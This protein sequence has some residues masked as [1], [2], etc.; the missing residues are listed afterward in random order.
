MK[1]LHLIALLVLA[2]AFS[3]S[4]QHSKVKIPSVQK[5]LN[6]LLITADDLD[7]N[8]LGCFGSTV[9]DISPNIDRFASQ[10]IRFEKAFVNAAICV[11]TRAI[12][13]TGLYGNN[14][15]VNGFNKM[16][17]GST[18]PL[19]MEI[20]RSHNYAVGILGKL[21]HSTPKAD[22]KWDYQFDQ[23]DL[24]FGRSPS[25]YYKRTKAF[26][27]DCRKNDKPFYFMINSQDPHRPFFNPNESA[28]SI[29]RRMNQPKARVEE[30][31]KDQEPPSRI[32]S[33]D[34]ITVPGFLP[35]LPK[36]REELSYYFNS[37]KRLDDAFGKVMQALEESGYADNTLVI[38]ISDNGIALP[39][40]KANVYNVSNRS[41]FIMRWPGTIK[42]G[43]VNNTDIVSIIDFMP[44]VLEALNIPAPKKIDGRSFLPLLKSGTQSGRD[45]AFME[46]DYKNSGG[47][48]PMRSVI[49]TQYN[50]IYN[51]WADGERVYGNN[52][53]GATMRAMEEA[54]KNDSAIAERI[55]VYYMRMPEEL[56]DIKKDP[57]C[58]HNLINEPGLKKQLASLR[59]DL[60]R[61]MIKTNDPLLKVYQVRHQPGKAL[62]EFYRIYPEA[63]EFDKNKENYSKA[64]RSND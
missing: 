9:P 37:V 44:T 43:S 27:D 53:E 28:D 14:S 38:F 8:S 32:Y 17:E 55:K 5:P 20:L 15:G 33:P 12:I 36:V 30:M 31:L 25:L 18:I 7:R 3:A 63:R 52:N 62:K 2:I 24:G 46:I 50:Y 47:P 4:A 60:E 11:P 23:Q 39:F 29:A 42:K 26:L 1:Q 21:S 51:A 22:F 58:L 13:A 41:P 61:W 64:G 57:D 40:A 48:T 35:D 49:T 56:Y 16:K 59:K 34:E 10:S 54:A 6:I 19:I 45:K